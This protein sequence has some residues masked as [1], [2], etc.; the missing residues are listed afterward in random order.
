MAEGER[1]GSNCLHIGLALIL[2]ILGDTFTA[3]TGRQRDLC[4]TGNDTVS[5]SGCV[6]ETPADPANRAHATG[7]EA[8]GIADAQ[9]LGR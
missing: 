3:I 2:A 5:T 1:L 4:P 8:D 6:Q 7:R 9:R